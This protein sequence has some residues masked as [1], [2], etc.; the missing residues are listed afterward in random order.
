MEVT[1]ST[2]AA[3][4]VQYFRKRAPKRS[5]KRHRSSNRKLQKHAGTHGRRTRELSGAK[6]IR[7]TLSNYQ[8]A[9]TSDKQLSLPVPGRLSHLNGVWSRLKA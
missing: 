6:Y 7:G 1:M 3:L 5:P 2:T 4:T 8:W 9:Y